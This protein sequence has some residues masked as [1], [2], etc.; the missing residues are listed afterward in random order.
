VVPWSSDDP[1]PVPLLSRPGRELYAAGCID[2]R[3]AHQLKTWLLADNTR[4]VVG[5]GNR[6]EHLE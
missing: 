1:L 3:T 2:Y 5:G 6:P 4:Q